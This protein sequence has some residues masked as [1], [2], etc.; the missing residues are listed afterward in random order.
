MY[1][2]FAGGLKVSPV[3]SSYTSR[4]LAHQI[5]TSQAAVVVVHP[6]LLNNLL[7]AFKL[8]GVSE[9]EARKRMILGDWNEKL[10]QPPPAGFVSINNL[11]GKG[12]LAEE[13]KFA[14]RYANETALLCFSSGTTGLAKGV[15]VCPFIETSHKPGF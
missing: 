9:D 7:D 1:A 8:L 13:A 6:I 14:G 15:E 2:G 4:E 3:N 11:I 5:H 12:K 10:D